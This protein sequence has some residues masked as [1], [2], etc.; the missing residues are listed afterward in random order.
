MG[1]GSFDA[2]SY[3]TYSD[4]IKSVPVDKI[5]T[6]HRL[7]PDLNPHVDQLQR[8]VKGMT[9]ISVGPTAADVMAEKR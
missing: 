5:Y 6:S 8:P 4:S 3:R 7:H 1:S 9:H 2:S